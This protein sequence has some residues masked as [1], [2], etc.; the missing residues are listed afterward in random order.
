MVLKLHTCSFLSNII[1]AFAMKIHMT[2]EKSLLSLGQMVKVSGDIF[3]KK[4]FADGIFINYLRFSNEISLEESLSQKDKLYH[5]RDSKVKVTSSYKVANGL[6]IIDLIL[7]C[8]IEKCFPLIKM[9]KLIKN[10]IWSKGTTFFFWFTIT[11][12]LLYRWPH[13]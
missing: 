12:N 6:V 7:W 1:V 2:E 5:V 9:H 13:T 8:S 4:W 3:G 10:I 11:T